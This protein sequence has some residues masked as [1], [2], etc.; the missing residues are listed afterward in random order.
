L[1]FLDL[2]KRRELHIKNEKDE[3]VGSIVNIYNE[4]LYELCTR[5]D[6]FEINFPSD[7]DYQKKLI[8]I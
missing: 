6:N 3:M 7:A 4:I 2:A 5:A 1:G 8:L